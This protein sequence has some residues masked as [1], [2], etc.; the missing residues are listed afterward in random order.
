MTGSN[1]WLGDR[2]PMALKE[3][4]LESTLQ[5]AEK[6]LRDGRYDQVV[7]TCTAVLRIIPDQPRATLFLGQ[8]YYNTNDCE[9]IPLLEKAIS[10][11]ETATLPIT[12]YHPETPV[13]SGFCSA[14]LVL[15]KHAIQFH[16][17]DAVS[18][19]FIVPR[20]GI[21]LLRNETYGEGML[22][23]EIRKPRGTREVIAVYYVYPPPVPRRFATGKK[24]DCQTQNPPTATSMLY[25]LLNGIMSTPTSQ[26]S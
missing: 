24:P 11:G 13:D 22:R 12:H 25:D 6:D 5:Q 15:S 17:N 26:R 21:H 3:G 14:N 4:Q 19:D 16:S 9:F 10:L 8:A 18:E 7:A 23:L 20:S 2:G 1:A